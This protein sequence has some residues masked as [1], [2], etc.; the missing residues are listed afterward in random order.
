MLSKYAGLPTRRLGILA[1]TIVALMVLILG[2][3]SLLAPL[4]I[5]TALFFV[6]GRKILQG[7]IVYRD[8]VDLKPPLI[9][10]LYA[11]AEFLFG[12]TGLSV[13]VFDL[14]WQSITI[15]LVVRLVRRITGSDLQGALTGLLYAGLLFS[16]TMYMGQ[17]ESFAAL[18]LTG[19]IHFFTRDSLAGT[20]VRVGSA[21]WCGVCAGT[22]MHLKPSFGIVVVA[23][24]AFDLIHTP[25]RLAPASWRMMALGAVLTVSLFPVYLVLGGAVQD[26]L[27]VQRYLEG[28][29]AV[30][31][32]HPGALFK[33]IMRGIPLY[34][35]N[36]WSVTFSVLTL[37]GMVASVMTPLQRVSVVKYGD[38]DDPVDRGIWLLRL[39]TLMLLALGI[40]ILV[41]AKL[42][43]WHFSRLFVP[44][45]TL[46]A[47]AILDI[48][49]RISSGAF[50][51]YARLIG[52]LF[53]ALAVL[54]SPLPRF[55]WH[56]VASIKSVAQGPAAFD[57]FMEGERSPYSMKEIALI[58]DYITAHRKPGD[59][60]FVASSAAALI[61]YA[62]G[63]VPDFRV[64][65]AC[66]LIPDYAPR[67]W[68]DEAREYLL[69][70]R[71]RFIV[72]QRDSVPD[73]TGTDLTSAEFL[74]SLKGVPDL[75]RNHYRVVLKTG[76]TI[77]FERVD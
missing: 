29:V 12:Q 77:L 28:Y 2:L 53:L 57:G 55:V 26:Y 45:A 20:R 32:S 5:D 35:G 48:A 67:R 52:G 36:T 15:F 66:F 30:Q 60:L 14:L 21:W 40:T 71:P 27:L 19:F 70:S 49:R 65:H 44:G 50:D 47:W 11:L 74:M 39:A 56:S 10:H 24:V 18:P 13:R 59:Q 64:Y 17:V 25:R 33:N 42:L 46:A 1:W 69:K 7:A 72:A 51:R 68:K 63:I 37:V 75:L 23:A 58:G 73:I 34:F 3:P 16:H 62:A 61:H 4:D 6:S 22:L 41:E 54:F 31:W 38:V 8:I 43:A 9:Y 76:L